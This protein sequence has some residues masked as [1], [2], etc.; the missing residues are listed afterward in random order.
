MTVNATNAEHAA[1][2][3]ATIA[4]VKRVP[5][6][7]R[8]FTS[9][10]LCGG[11]AA[12]ATHDLAGLGRGN[13]SEEV[14]RLGRHSLLVVDELDGVCAGVALVRGE[15]AIHAQHN[16]L[17]GQAGGIGPPADGPFD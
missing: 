4:M 2:A 17:F 6:D 3:V 5:R 14:A 1:S 8:L 7:D 11:D 15:Q 9:T 10:S 13:E 12:H 16:N